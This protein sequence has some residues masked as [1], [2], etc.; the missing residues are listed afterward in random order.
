VEVGERYSI[1]RRSVWLML[2]RA[3]SKQWSGTMCSIVSA[4][5]GRNKGESLGAF[6]CLGLI[7]VCLTSDCYAGERSGNF[8]VLWPASLLAQREL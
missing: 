3:S 7:V 2:S 8:I 6:A 5:D 4:Q 1:Q